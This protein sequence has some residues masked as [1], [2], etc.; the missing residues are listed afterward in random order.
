MTIQHEIWNY[1]SFAVKSEHYARNFTASPVVNGQKPPPARTRTAW[2]AMMYRLLR[3]MWMPLQ[4][5]NNC[6]LSGLRYC[7]AQQC[8]RLPGPPKDLLPEGLWNKGT[9]CRNKGTLV[10]RCGRYSDTY[11]TCAGRREI[12][13]GAIFRAI[14]AQTPPRGTN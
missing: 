13:V 12:L 14:Q 8:E 1:Q 4:Q 11:T 5:A 10:H 9:P 7:V 2:N 3:T 6:C